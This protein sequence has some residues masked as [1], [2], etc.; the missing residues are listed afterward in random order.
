MNK[1]AEQLEDLAQ[2]LQTDIDNMRVIDIRKVVEELKRRASILRSSKN[3]KVNYIGSNDT[4]NIHRPGYLE[5]QTRQ[6]INNLHLVQAIDRASLRGSRIFK[7]G[8]EM[9]FGED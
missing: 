5:S 1:L 2:E 3:I 7:V 4:I 8:S 6:F 9:E